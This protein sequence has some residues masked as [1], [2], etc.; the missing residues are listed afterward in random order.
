MWDAS[1]ASQSFTPRYLVE[2]SSEGPRPIAASTAGPS[3]TRADPVRVRAA[4]R[5]ATVR[6]GGPTYFYQCTVCG[7]TF[8]R[9]AMD[10]T[11]DPHKHQQGNPCH[12]SHGV[13][14]KTKS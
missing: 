11:P 13:Y 7:K 3:V 2:L 5:R 6:S 8:D 12:G 4:P 9:K 14:A 10:G 1:V